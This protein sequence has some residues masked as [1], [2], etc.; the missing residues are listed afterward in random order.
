MAKAADDR[1]A[2][3]AAEQLKTHKVASVAVHPGWVR[4][5]GVMLYAGHLDLTHS[6]SPEGV[7]RA[8]AAPASDPGLLSLTGQALGVEQLAARHHIDVR[9]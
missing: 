4:T 7:G 3:A 1:L 2:R 6:Q 5:E 8:I 9:S